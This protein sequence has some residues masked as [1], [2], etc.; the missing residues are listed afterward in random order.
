M[1]REPYVSTAL[2]LGVWCVA[3]GPLSYMEPYTFLMQCF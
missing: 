2:Q 1:A 3:I